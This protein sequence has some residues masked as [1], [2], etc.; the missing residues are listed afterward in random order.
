MG[1]ADDD[2][3]QTTLTL[4]GSRLQLAAADTLLVSFSSQALQPRARA[5]RFA[6]RKAVAVSLFTAY[7]LS[8]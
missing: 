7:R 8:S 3:L 4:K 6:N 5:V 1:N 2:R